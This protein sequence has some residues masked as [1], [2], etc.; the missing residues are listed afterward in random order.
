MKSKNNQN[1]NTEKNKNI[2]IATFAGG[3]FW[4]MIPPFENLPGVLRA[5]PGYTGGKTKNPSYEEVVS[6]TTGHMESVQVF[7]NPKKVSY[8]KLL[9]VFWQQINPEDAGGQFADRG[10]QY[11]TA[12]FYH[13]S[14]QKNLAIASKKALEKSGKFKKIATRIIKAGEFYIAEQYHWDYHKKNP[15][16]YKIYKKMSGRENF[17]NKT[18]KK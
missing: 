8:E 3:Y 9:D 15:I 2:A 18:W 14:K 6:G 13:D 12:I 7:Y 10:N 17:I 16:Q 4:C 1:K 5:I 11:M